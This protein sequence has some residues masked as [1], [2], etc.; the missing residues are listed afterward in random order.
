MWKENV[1]LVRWGICYFESYCIMMVAS[2]CTKW[3]CEVL[4]GQVELTEQAENMLK[5]REHVAWRQK[6]WE[7]ADAL[8]RSCTSEERTRCETE[9]SSQECALEGGCLIWSSDHTILRY[10]LLSVFCSCYH[11]VITQLDICRIVLRNGSVENRKYTAATSTVMLA[12]DFLAQCYYSLCSFASR[13][14]IWY[15]VCE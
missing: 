14:F 13:W 10:Q 1:S 11:Q 6:W 12:S 4:K 3:N 5:K 7:W 15:L 8:M 2:A 9:I